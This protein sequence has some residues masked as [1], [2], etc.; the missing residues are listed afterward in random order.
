MTEYSDGSANWQRDP[1]FMNFGQPVQIPQTRA[2]LLSQHEHLEIPYDASMIPQ[3]TP[4]A[5]NPFL[6]T[7]DDSYLMGE[8]IAASGLHDPTPAAFG[9]FGGDLSERRT[10]TAPD[11]QSRNM[12][13][14]NDQ[15]GDEITY[16]GK[17]KGKEKEGEGGR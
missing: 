3:E 8:M 10:Y 2:L 1:Y 4:E 17:G 13:W 14:S 6:L 15:Q 16:E 9:K 12:D 11:P 5:V 7:P